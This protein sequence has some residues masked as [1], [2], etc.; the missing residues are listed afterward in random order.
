MP[1]CHDSIA[2]EFS[3]SSP[4]SYAGEFNSSEG[5][6]AMSC[7]GSQP[8][9]HHRPNNMPPRKPSAAQRST[10][11]S[12]LSSQRRSVAQSDRH[13]VQVA[14]PFAD[15]AFIEQAAGRAA[16]LYSR[17]S[18]KKERGIVRPS[19]QHGSDQGSSSSSN[20]S[21][22]PVQ[23]T[24]RVT[25]VSTSDPKPI[26]NIEGGSRKR[27]RWGAV[28]PR[29]E[30]LF[31]ADHSMVSVEKQANVSSLVVERHLAGGDVGDSVAQQKQQDNESS[32]VN[33]EP[34]SIL[35]K[36][37]Q[38]ARKSDE[39]W[40]R[41]ITQEITSESSTTRCHQQ[42]HTTNNADQIENSLTTSYSNDSRNGTI[43]THAGGVHLPEENISRIM[44]TSYPVAG[45]DATTGNV[46]GVKRSSEPGESGY[47]LQST[48]FVEVHDPPVAC[49]MWVQVERSVL[50]KAQLDA[51]KSNGEYRSGPAMM[52]DSVYK[53]KSTF[54][55]HE[56]TSRLKQKSIEQ[57]DTGSHDSKIPPESAPKSK[58]QDS[59]AELE[60]N[61]AP[62]KKKRPKDLSPFRVK[63]GCVVAL[64]FRKLADGG[65][66]VVSV[67]KDGDSF[68][69]TKPPRESDAA[70]K[71][72]DV[73][74]KNKIGLANEYHA[75]AAP[76][77]NPD[78]NEKPG[79]IG[80]TKLL[81][82]ENIDGTKRTSK[83]YEIWSPAI[84]GQDDGLSLLGS[85]I[86]CIF[87]KSFIKRWQ[88]ENMNGTNG[89]PGRTVEGNVISILENDDC[90]R[91]GVTA[92]ILV[93]RTS[94]KSLPYL[95][96][97]ADDSNDSRLSSSEQKR[98]KLEAKIRGED[99][100]VV[101]V[102]LASVFHQRYGSNLESGVVSQWALRKRVFAKPAGE[103]PTKKE[104]SHRKQCAQSI[105]VGD[106]NDTQIQQKQNWRW[107]A[108]RTTCLPNDRENN[109]SDLGT[110]RDSVSQLVGEV[111]KMDVNP[112]SE[113]STTLANV[114]IK[115]LLTP[116][117][118]QGGRMTHH[119]PLEL[120]DT[121]EELY[122]QVPIEDLI[123]IGKRL[124]RLTDA[125]NKSNIH[126]T[127]RDDIEGS[128]T[129]THS[130]QACEN[131]FTPLS[132]GG[133][134]MSSCNLDLPLQ[135][136]VVRKTTIEPM[137]QSTQ[138]IIGAFSGLLT[139][140]QSTSSF[141]DFTLPKDIGK[142]SLRPS[143]LPLAG[144]M[145]SKSYIKGIKKEENKKLVKI[146]GKSKKPNT[147][148]KLA[149]KLNAVLDD[150]FPDEGVQQV[151]EPL[152]IRAV[153]FDRLTK[154][155]WGY[156]KVKFSSSICEPFFREKGR[157]RAIK[158]GKDEEKSTLSGRAARA[159]SRRMLKSL[160][161]LVDASKTV[162]RLAGRHREHQLRFDKSR[163]HGW[164]VYA[165]E[166]IN[167]GDMIIEY[168]GE[169]I[170]NAVADKRE[171]EYEKAKMDDYM[172]RIDSVTVCDATMLGN[173]ARYIN[174]SCSPNCF[175]QIITAGENKRIV[176]YAKRDIHRGEELCY[177]YKFSY[178][179][180]Q[181]KR[182][183][184]NCGSPMCRGFMN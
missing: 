33:P 36:V 76:Q 106:G 72:S 143:F 84:P 58:R 175:T 23:E 139:S 17:Q 182:I 89:S 107:I 44:A 13:R 160:A 9:D 54:V 65:N 123:V 16:L 145:R 43:T 60:V 184:C 102:N 116:E 86:R 25:F 104:R 7:D 74:C 59:S 26:N 126:R 15:K 148:I 176:I 82:K 93:D 122:L 170:G 124:L 167:M 108:S 56:E 20:R 35:R 105:F 141:I 78:Q 117:Q 4:S 94:T 135:K 171:Q 130:Y 115:R 138:S 114:T 64:R 63:V 98:R 140:L 49:N 70:L 103:K 1:P 77:H 156:S 161:G 3:I 32:K 85:W 10:L 99:K 12:L 47:D 6:S 91:N 45:A 46:D 81:G 118:I 137:S 178:E 183:P 119:G 87:Q 53:S 168:R 131:I 158:I 134:P 179:D 129:I 149:K 67:V 31:C 177:D 155:C 19:S 169:I 2:I 100:V 110:V 73:F 51:P 125:G 173:V 88:K 30:P 113:G 5:D 69:L 42:I 128:F 11:A 22:A 68:H 90:K 147:R 165:E 157:P 79:A 181:S 121:S 153:P 163:I 133:V 37:K 180:D 172:F 151:S 120:F 101:H 159:H 136:K 166:L 50:E 14:R 48:R 142:L 92:C 28:K 112:A 150:E 132:V 146:I 152:C 8:N 66:E 162:D 18:E 57:E 71:K 80:A 174:A 41:F 40:Q 97:I 29:V 111:V 24:R 154:N 38:S 52:R 83:P 62:P 61:S 55:Q 109:H 39:S 164:G 96:V 27:S 144:L 75:E 127:L 34:K 21:T 95:Q